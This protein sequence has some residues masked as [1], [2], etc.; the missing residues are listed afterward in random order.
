M[1]LR[2][3]VVA[4]LLLAS[5]V[6]VVAATPA[7]AEERLA[8]GGD[9][10]A[11]EAVARAEVL[12]L[13]ERH[14]A[15][16]VELVRLTA[17]LPAATD[18][19]ADRPAAHPAA[20]APPLPA[21]AR[22]RTDPL[23]T[24]PAFGSLTP[25][26]L[27]F[28]VQLRRAVATVDRTAVVEAEVRTVF[29]QLIETR[30][31]LAALNPGAAFGIGPA[32]FPVG[33]T[34]EFEDSW[35]NPRSGGRRHKGTDVLAPLGV[36]LYAVESGVIERYD[37]HPLGGLSLYLQGDS[38]ARYYYAHLAG[39]GPYAEG[40]RVEVGSVIGFNGDTGNARGVPHLHFQFAPEGG[41]AWVNP[42]PLLVALQDA[43]WP[44]V[45]LPASYAT[46]VPAP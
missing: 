2:T 14:D 26:E 6:G 22:T 36:P 29:E 19:S 10:P 46:G 30:A 32:V 15:L 9:E 27:A 42:Y 28:T 31:A 20:I 17:V 23:L 1:S 13:L 43:V 33:G 39:F 25:T 21:G 35:G 45:P 38:G 16:T 5:G 4:V 44:G 3:R 12:A 11:E 37:D 18:T 40:D 24:G 34:Y 8:P 7:G 41:E